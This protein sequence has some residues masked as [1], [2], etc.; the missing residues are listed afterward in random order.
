M[1]KKGMTQP[2]PP[3]ERACMTVG[4]PETEIRSVRCDVS[5]KIVEVRLSTSEIALKPNAFDDRFALP[6][7]GH[8]CPI[9]AFSLDA[10]ARK[11]SAAFS[12]MSTLMPT[13]FGAIT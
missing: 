4:Y 11:C 12:A 5:G 10:L 8:F 1:Q 6:R 2:T 7:S 13:T 3:A 9:G